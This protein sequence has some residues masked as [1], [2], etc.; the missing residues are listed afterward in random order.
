MAAVTGW[1]KAAAR[2][3]L[4][5][6]SYKYDW[7]FRASYSFVR[8]QLGYGYRREVM[9]K[10]FNNF[11]AKAGGEAAVRAWDSLKP[12]SRRLMVDTELRQPYK[13]RAYMD[14]TQR[15]VKTGE[16][17]TRRSS[18]Y[19]DF[20]DTFLDVEIEYRYNWTE[21]MSKY[22]IHIVGFEMVAIEHDEE[23]EY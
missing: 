15:D 13:Y 11:K 10:D 18:M 23:S 17:W 21:M 22:D 3:M 14:V 20:A 4:E 8:Q 2:A 9:L 6:I 16:V 12:V 1:M 19:T 5:S 7:S